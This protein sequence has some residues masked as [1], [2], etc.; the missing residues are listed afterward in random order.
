M[1]SA[2][3]RL[4]FEFFARDRYDA[5]SISGRDS[6]MALLRCLPKY[7]TVSPEAAWD[8]IM[9]RAEQKRTDLGG[10]L[11]GGDDREDLGCTDGRAYFDE[12][13]LGSMYMWRARTVLAEA[14]HWNL[15]ADPG[16]HSYKE[17]MPAVA[18]S[19]EL[20][21]AAYPS[22][23][24]ILPGKWVTSGDCA[25]AE[26]I[27]PVADEMKLERV[28]A[29]RQLQGKQ[30]HRQ[31]WACPG[32]EGGR[33]SITCGEARGGISWCGRYGP[34]IDVRGPRIQQHAR[35]S[36]EWRSDAGVLQSAR[37]F[38]LGPRWARRVQAQCRGGERNAGSHSESHH[39][40][41]SRCVASRRRQ[42][43]YAS[44]G[45]RRGIG[46]YC[47]RGCSGL[48]AESDSLGSFRLCPQDYEGSETC[49]GLLRQAIR[50]NEA[51]VGLLVRPE[52]PPVWQW[53][54]L[55]TQEP[56]AVYVS[57]FR[58]LQAAGDSGNS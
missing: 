40:A 51:L 50:Q 37:V 22:W 20:D 31:Q 38:L 35:P 58:I 1:D 15:V 10:F 6:L 19:W 27:V 21:Q 53:L 18:Y 3:I 36:D 8:A 13:K 34:E 4:I 46:G 54:Q 48:P 55:H 30:G 39:R 28:A 23:Q 26:D 16:T 2:A 11:R 47:W 17:V 42:S 41:G 57:M 5:S 9:E 29:Y 7:T 32:G 25:M 56:S 24:H 14:L 44:V 43:T 12:E 49:R 33:N 45:P 52:Q